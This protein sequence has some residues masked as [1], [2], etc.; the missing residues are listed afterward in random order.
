[1]ILA[2]CSKCKEV[3]LACVVLGVIRC[4]KCGSEETNVA[5]GKAGKA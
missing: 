2:I 3:F 5:I 4:P 1:M